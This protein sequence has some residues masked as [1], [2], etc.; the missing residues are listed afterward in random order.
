MKNIYKAT[1]LV[2]DAYA[3]QIVG[4][5]PE[6]EI[7]LVHKLQ[8][9]FNVAE[10]IMDIFFGEK[11]VYSL[12]NE[13]E[14]RMV[15]IAAVLHDLGRFYQHKDGHY[16]SGKEFDHG[17]EAVKLIKDIAGVNDPKILFAIAEH[18][19]KAI[20]Y[21]NP[22]YKAMTPEEQHK[23]DIMA[24]LLRD[25]DKIENINCFVYFGMERL[26]TIPDGGLSDGVKQDIVAK[27]TINYANVKTSSDSLA[28]SLA[29]VNDIYYNTT[30]QKLKKLDFLNY[31]IEQIKERGASR[32]D[33]AFLK[34]HLQYRTV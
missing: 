27:K 20:D 29:W 11:D 25:A 15:K 2:G 13:E 4:A 5:S 19:H 1:K 33:I 28:I 22:I 32:E 34:E 12:F 10:E 6:V 8:H 23:A 18:N 3:K 16:I 9:T 24:K 17:W 21:E 31:G 14:R 30:V 26:G 7:W